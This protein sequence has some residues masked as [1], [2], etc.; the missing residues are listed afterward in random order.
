MTTG[1]VWTYFICIKSQ[2][3]QPLLTEIIQA[4]HLSLF[5]HITYMDDSTI[6]D[7]K[8]NTEQLMEFNGMLWAKPMC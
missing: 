6:I 5:V 8:I 3:D 2:T 1:K 4:W 7:W